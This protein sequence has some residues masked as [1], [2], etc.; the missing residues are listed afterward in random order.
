MKDTLGAILAAVLDFKWVVLGTIVGV[1][2]VAKCA[3]GAEAPTAP[4]PYAPMAMAEGETSRILVQIGTF[5]CKDGQHRA[6]LVNEQ[7]WL[8]I[9]CATTG[10]RSIHIEWENGT[11]TDVDLT[12]GKTDGPVPEK[13]AHP[14]VTPE[15]NS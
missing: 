15:R 9:G 3:H 6:V 13:P 8:K 4:S 7:G 1:L 5:S 2:A 12:P 10:A 14:G 11:S